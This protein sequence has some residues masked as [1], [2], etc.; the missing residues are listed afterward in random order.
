MPDNRI[1][2]SSKYVVNGVTR[3]TTENSITKRPYAKTDVSSDKRHN[4]SNSFDDSLHSKAKKKA[5]TDD[6]A[7]FSNELDNML[8]LKSEEN[9]RLVQARFNHHD[10]VEP[11]PIANPIETEL[12]NKLGQAMEKGKIDASI[13]TKKIELLNALRHE[14]K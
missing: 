12:H 11:K 9:S 2:S 14:S 13:L 4:N 7:S 8:R 3:I 10:L 5:H 1:I 6:S